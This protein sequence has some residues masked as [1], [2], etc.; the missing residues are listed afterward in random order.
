MKR[1]LWDYFSRKGWILGPGALVQLAVGWSTGVFAGKP[2]GNPVM[3]VEVQ[4]GVFMGAFLLSLDLQRGLARTLLPLPLSALQIGRAWWLAT[5]AIPA[6]GFSA[7]LVAGAGLYCFFHPGSSPDWTVLG[8]WS[9][10][11]LLWMGASFTIIFNMPQAAACASNPWRRALSIAL[12]IGW[13]LMFGGGFWLARNA[14]ENPLN[15]AGLAL[16]GLGL[17]V[18]GWFRCGEFFQSQASFRITSSEEPAK[19]SGDSSDALSR[20]PSRNDG[21]G[22]L[23]LL[24]R[25]LL[26][27]AFTL[28]LLVLFA[29][30]LFSGFQNGKPSWSAMAAALPYS[31]HLAVFIISF[32]VLMKVLGQLR[33]LRSLPLS[34]GWIAGVVIGAILVPHVLFSGLACAATLAASGPEAALEVAKN[35]AV[36]LIPALIM[37]SLTSWQGL[38]Q[39][40]YTLAFGLMIFAQS[41]PLWLP[42]KSVPFPMLGLLAAGSVAFAWLFT[43][44]ALF[45]GTKAYRL[46]AYLAA[47]GWSGASTR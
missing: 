27:H 17:S 5:V 10:A 40:S 28:G 6:V 11:L 29:A 9:L 42:L 34:A 26:T 1:L 32:I 22:G 39:L 8:N 13:G 47:W 15:G 46:P 38:G 12:G 19:N 21:L 44:H 23:A 7:L 3:A 33:L 2:H 25:D 43:R 41:L 36:L 16:V 35:H 31:S 20:P 37:V 30:P 24:V 45:Y 4:I 14:T 18:F